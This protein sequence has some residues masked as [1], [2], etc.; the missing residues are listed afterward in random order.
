MKFDLVRVW[1]DEA[2]RQSLSNEQLPANPAGELAEAEL[3]TVHGGCCGANSSLFTFA[4]EC[5]NTLFSLNFNTSAALFSFPTNVCI[6][7][8]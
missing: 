3:D 5:E 4:V 2:Y 1:K 6:N 8:E 7:N